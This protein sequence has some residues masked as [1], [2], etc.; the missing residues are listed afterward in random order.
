MCGEILT[1]MRV[2]S[3]IN[4]SGISAEGGSIGTPGFYFSWH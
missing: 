2:E 1:N 4:H 3:S